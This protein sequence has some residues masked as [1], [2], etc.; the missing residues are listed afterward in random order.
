[1]RKVAKLSLFPVNVK[2]DWIVTCGGSNAPEGLPEY[3][4]DVDLETEFQCGK[5]HPYVQV[6]NVDLSPSWLHCGLVYYRQRLWKRPAKNVPFSQIDMLQ[7]RYVSSVEVF[8]P[9]GNA[10]QI[11]TVYNSHTRV[12]LCNNDVAAA[13]AADSEH[14]YANSPTDCHFVGIHTTSSSDEDVL[15]YQ[16][17][18]VNKVRQVTNLLCKVL[19]YRTVV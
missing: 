5:D 4:I 10:F 17:D 18:D 1:M 11:G 6:R 7:G 14:Y 16:V 3:L 8:F 19:L 13:Y 12:F 15:L 9:R 2:E